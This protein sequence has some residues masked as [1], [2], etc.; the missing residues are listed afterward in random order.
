MA[1]TLSGIRASRYPPM[2]GQ[3]FMSRPERSNTSIGA[4]LQPLSACEAR[5]CWCLAFLCGLPTYGSVLPA[6]A[7]TAVTSLTVMVPLALMS[8]RNFAPLNGR[9]ESALMYAMSVAVTDPEPFT[10]P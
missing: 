8:A 10:S 1:D 3:G 7:F 9:A 6:C 4:P 2:M 5:P